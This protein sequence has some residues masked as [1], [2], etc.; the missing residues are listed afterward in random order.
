MPNVGKSTLINALRLAHA[1]EFHGDNARRSRTAERV[2]IAPGTTRAPRLV[3]LSRDPPLVLWDTPGLTLPGCFA[4]EAGLRLAACGIIPTNNLSLPCGVVARYIYDILLTAGMREHLAECLHLSRPPI[5]F[6]DCI[7]LICER[8][9]SSGQSELGNLDA[10]RAH[11]FLLYD[12]QAGNLGRITLDPLPK[13][14]LQT[15]DND[16]SASRLLGTVA[17]TNHAEGSGPHENENPHSSG[18]GDNDNDEDATF[19]H[20]VESVEV[21]ER[22]PEHMREVMEALR[23]PFVGGRPYSSF[24]SSSRE[25]NV[26]SRRKGP[27]SR[28]SA[29]EGEYR[30]CIRLAEG[31]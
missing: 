29:F 28:A 6:D 8:S 30:K 20:H 11:R 3:P 18:D 9:G 22:Y 25:E 21:V 12:F 13:K 7:S 5:S 26:I 15:P 2:G 4:R 10:A 19:T 24:S 23:G 17:S 16:T 27:I 31:R 14:A 1:A